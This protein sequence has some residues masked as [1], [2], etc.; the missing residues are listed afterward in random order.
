MSVYIV[1]SVFFQ[2]RENSQWT[3][4]STTKIKVMRDFIL[5]VNVLKSNIIYSR[6]T[7]LFDVSSYYNFTEV[8]TQFCR[9][10]FNDKDEI[11]LLTLYKYC[12]IRYKYP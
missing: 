10:G 6:Q 7:F 3:D 1:F 4:N 8:K 5:E 12:L 9:K 2:K 11:E